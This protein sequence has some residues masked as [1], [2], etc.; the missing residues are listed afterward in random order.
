[1]AAKLARFLISQDPVC[2]TLSGSDSV[3][4]EHLKLL[5]ELFA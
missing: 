4:D 5:S 2:Q 3:S 1:M